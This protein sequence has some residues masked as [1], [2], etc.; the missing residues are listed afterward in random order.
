MELE[1]L[2]S[3]IVSRAEVPRPGKDTLKLTQFASRQ[4]GK[5]VLDLGTGSGFIAIFFALNGR[6]VT[7]SDINQKALEVAKENADK[8]KLKIN[9]IHSN[10]FDNINEKFDLII[11]NPPIGNSSGN[12]FFELIKRFI[13][14]RKLTLKLAHKIFRNERKQLIKKFASQSIKHLNKNGRI[15]I[16]LHESERKIIESLLPNKI[17]V[18]E[19]YSNYNNFEIIQINR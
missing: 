11:F 7:A 19:H 1:N 16:M 5:K 14:K 15:V 4:P 10:L 9:F 8:F 12:F 3:K 18:L 13:P 2:K 17:K 6:E